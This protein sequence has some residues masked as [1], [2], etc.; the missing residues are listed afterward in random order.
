MLK[1]SWEF[2]CKRQRIAPATF[3]AKTR[4]TSYVELV[5][6]LKS[7]GVAPPLEADVKSF[8][9]KKILPKSKPAAVKNAATPKKPAKLKPKKDDNTVAAVKKKARRPRTTRQKLGVAANKN[10]DQKDASQ[11]DS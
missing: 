3:I 11:S 8:F 7:R 4:C 9:E 2:F 10:A 1:I 5:D 6:I